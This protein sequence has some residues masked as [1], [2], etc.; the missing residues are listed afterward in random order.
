MV[1]ITIGTIETIRSP[2]DSWGNR[3]Y[4]PQFYYSMGVKGRIFKVSA[5]V[6]VSR[7]TWQHFPAIVRVS[8]RVRSPHPATNAGF[9][10]TVIL[11]FVRSSC[12]CGDGI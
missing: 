11:E 6:R 7:V 9:A 8:H 2:D 10:M 5:P 12:E 1:S 4:V 3:I